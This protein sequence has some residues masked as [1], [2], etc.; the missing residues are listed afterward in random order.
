MRSAILAL[1]LLMAACGGANTPAVTVNGPPPATKF[2]ARYTSGGDTVTFTKVSA[3]W[4]SENT[5]AL[6]FLT[7]A[8]GP[9][10]AEEMDTVP[11][12]P[13]VILQI[14]LKDRQK[15]L[16]VDNVDSAMLIVS[17]CPRPGD[18][19]IERD[20]LPALKALSGTPAS[21]YTLVLEFDWKSGDKSMVAS[22]N[23]KLK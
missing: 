19:H 11:E 9:R 1:A 5:L 10:T 21:G 15:G 20:A 13:V 22:V 3:G 23:D 18:R 2:E 7:D 12:P 4:A 6:K 8:V 16:A 14:N 17:D